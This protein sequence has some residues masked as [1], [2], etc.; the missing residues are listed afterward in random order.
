MPLKP[1]RVYVPAS[2]TLDASGNGSCFVSAP[3]GTV[4]HVYLISINT[5]ETRTT[6]A[7]PRFNLYADNAPNRAHYIEGSGSGNQD[8]SDSPHVIYGGEYLCGEWVGGTP[9][10]IATMVVRAM[11]QE[12]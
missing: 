5:T 1:Q 7:P 9:G 12:L 3:S 11:Q 2:V 10:S 4:W 8:T 6:V